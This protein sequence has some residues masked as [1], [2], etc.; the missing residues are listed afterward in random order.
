VHGACLLQNPEGLVDKHI[1]RCGTHR[2]VHEL[3]SHGVS[4][5]YDVS[6]MGAATNTEFASFGCDTPPGFLNLLTYSSA[7]IRTA[8]FHAESVYGVEALRGF[9]LPVAAT[10]FVAPCPFSQRRTPRKRCI[11]IAPRSDASTTLGEATHDSGILAPGRSVR[12]EAVLP[13]SAGRSSL[14]LCAPL[15]ISPLEPWPQ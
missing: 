7:L 4:F 3:L 14:S 11:S 6:K 10:T 2:P 1:S 9:P 8:L 12:D 13:N 15:R 5:P